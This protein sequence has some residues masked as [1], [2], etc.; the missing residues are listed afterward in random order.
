MQPT[1]STVLWSDFQSWGAA[2]SL[3]GEKA[4]GF[5]SSSVL[6]VLLTSRN[7]YLADKDLIKPNYCKLEL[8]KFRLKCAPHFSTKENIKLLVASTMGYGGYFNH[9]KLSKYQLLCYNGCYSN[10]AGTLGAEMRTL[11]PFVLLYIA[12]WG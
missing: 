8:D 4:G 10:I 9:R 3:M 11:N 2:N 6:S 7:S 5:H 12:H 1:L